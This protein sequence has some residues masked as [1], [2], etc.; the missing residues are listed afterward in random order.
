MRTLVAFGDSLTEGPGVEPDQTYPAQLQRRLRDQGLAWSV[1]NAGK[2]GE[3]SSGARDRLGEILERKP[4]AVLLEIGGNDGFRGLKVE[5][6]RKNISF[7]VEEIRREN[8]PVMLAGMRTLVD[9]GPDYGNRFQAIYP[10]IARELRVP[11]IPFFLE[12]VSGDARWNQP[13]LV[14]PTERGYGRIVDHI[15]PT[16]IRWLESLPVE[17]PR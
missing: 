10:A 15:A 5:T 9:F 11:L 14:H 16:V 8:I 12:G 1:V 7:I 3:T 13:D 17:G 2:S 6:S 4:H